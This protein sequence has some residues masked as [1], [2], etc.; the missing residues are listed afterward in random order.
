M[1][2]LI[3]ILVLGIIAVICGALLTVSSIF[4]GVKAQLGTGWG[5]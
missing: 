5:V 3:P 1:E 2:I 4:F